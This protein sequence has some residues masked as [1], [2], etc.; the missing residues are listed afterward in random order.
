MID[1]GISFQKLSNKEETLKR[2]IEKV[3]E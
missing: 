3:R 1:Q 2:C